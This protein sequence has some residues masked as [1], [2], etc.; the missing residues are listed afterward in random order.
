MT[1][2]ILFCSAE[3]RQEEIDKSKIEST[4]VTEESLSDAYNKYA[5]EVRSLYLLHSYCPLFRL[6]NVDTQLVS[7]C[8]IFRRTQ[9][10]IG[11]LL[12][13]TLTNKL[14]TIILQFKCFEVEL[15]IQTSELKIP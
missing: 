5:T 10:F 13:S 8:P 7:R 11:R 4:I 12:V 15:Q 2:L 9:S 14:Q 6:V 3:G 1:S